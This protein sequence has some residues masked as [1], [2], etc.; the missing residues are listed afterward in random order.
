M[1]RYQFVRV[2]WENEKNEAFLL[3]RN[4]ENNEFVKKKFGKR[5]NLIKEDK[6]LCLGY[7]DYITKEY[8]PCDKNMDMTGSKFDRCFSCNGLDGFS[9]CLYCKGVDCKASVED[10]IAYCNEP[11]VVYLTYFGQDK[12]KVGTTSY[13]RRYERLLEQGAS[14]SLIIATGT[15]KQVRKIEDS[16]GKLGVYTVIQPSYKLKNLLYLDNSNYE[17]LLI[18]KFNWIKENLEE[19]YSL[20]FVKGQFISFDNVEKLDKVIPKSSSQLSLFGG[21]SEEKAEYSIIKETSEISGEVLG[22]LGQLIVYKEKG[23]VK[24]VNLKKWQGYIIEV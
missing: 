7:H 3:L 15:G 6:K 13:K 24:V 22:V 18:S 11:H 17:S 12:F 1:K 5:I 8:H 4:L 20:N 23:Q 16:I 10:V 2:K 19:D 21:S 9:T 14:K